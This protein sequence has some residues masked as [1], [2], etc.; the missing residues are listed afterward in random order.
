MVPEMQVS[1]VDADSDLIVHDTDG[2]L[3]DDA[4]NSADDDSPHD[5]WHHFGKL[6]RVSFNAND[7][8]REKKIQ[9]DFRTRKHHKKT[10]EISQVPLPENERN[11][12]VSLFRTDQNRAV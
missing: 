10:L 1:L 12:K 9:H 7:L 3:D 6:F 5:L 4:D 2:A 8:R 11:E